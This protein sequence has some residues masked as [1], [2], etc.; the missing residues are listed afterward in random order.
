MTGGRAT[1][2]VADDV[3]V[4]KNSLTQSM[5]DKLGQA[6]KEFDAVLVPGGEVTSLG[7]LRL[8]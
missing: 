3:E 1:R 7:H 6:V 8:R 4:P 2:I 5:R